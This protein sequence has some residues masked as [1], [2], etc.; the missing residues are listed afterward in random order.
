MRSYET[1]RLT[2]R[3]WSQE[4]AEFVFDLYSRWEVQQFIGTAPQ[5][6]RNRAEALLRLE[7]WMAMDHPV[8]GIWAVEET[9]TAR[10]AGVLLLK[11][12]PA[13]RDIPDAPQDTEIGWHFHPGFW[14]RGYA[15]EAAAVILRHAFDSGLPEVV[16]VTNPANS[17]SRRVCA[18]I[19]MRHLGQTTRYYD[20]TC[21]LYSAARESPFL[22]G[23]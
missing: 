20:T 17:A 5:V 9:L 16:A 7:K 6:M 8:H 13:S 12:I 19:G 18:R 15:S 2:L 10:V 22:P 11:P 23:G 1:A 4:D 21:E 3:P 14:G